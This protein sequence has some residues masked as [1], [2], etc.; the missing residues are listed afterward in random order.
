M[1]G[2]HFTPVRSEAAAPEVDEDL[3]LL[4][5]EFADGKSHARIRYVDN[6]VDALLIEPVASGVDRDVG[7]IL[8]V[9]RN[10]IHL[11][12]LFRRFEVFDRQFGGNDKSFTGRVGIDAR[13]IIQYTDLD[14]CLRTCCRRRHEGRRHNQQSSKA[15]S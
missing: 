9:R 7:L 1:F 8:V 15:H 10:D 13:P 14:L 5:G 3:V 6:D 11:H 4:P 2:E 12:A